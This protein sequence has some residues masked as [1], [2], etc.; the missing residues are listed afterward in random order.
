MA[1]LKLD[2]AKAQTWILEVS[3]EVRD[4]E[5]TL[6][7][8]EELVNKPVDTDG[9]DDTLFEVMKDVQGKM[10]EV[11]T[12]ASN[13]FRDTWEAI[14]EEVKGLSLWGDEFRDKVRRLLN[15]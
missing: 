5:D 13:V 11:Y 15:R 9:D 4:V 7:R 3:S 1:D 6:K 8:V 10:D 14:D 2:T 12:R